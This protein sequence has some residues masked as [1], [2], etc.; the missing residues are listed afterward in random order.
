MQE[1][2]QPLS[3]LGVGPIGRVFHSQERPTGLAQLIQLLSEGGTYASPEI[4]AAF[5]PLESAGN[6]PYSVFRT[7]DG[8]SFLALHRQVTESVSV[9]SLTRK[10]NEYSTDERDV[11]GYIAA[12]KYSGI[13][14]VSTT[15]QDVLNA[16]SFTDF[17][18]S[19]FLRWIDTFYPAL[20]PIRISSIDLVS[21]LRSLD[22]VPGA[23]LTLLRSTIRFP[24]SGSQTTERAEKLQTVL[25]RADDEQGFLDRATIELG[26][27]DGYTMSIARTGLL[28]YHCGSLSHA[29]EDY[30]QLLDR[31][32]T[33]KAAVRSVDANPTQTY[34]T[35]VQIR[36]T[37]PIRLGLLEAASALVQTLE[38]DPLYSVTVMHGNPYLHVSVTDLAQGATYDVFSN[39]EGSLRV[40]P[41]RNAHS[42]SLEHLLMRIS[43]NFSDISSIEVHQTV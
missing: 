11:S 6:S 22:Q 25:A 26:G 1:H 31:A 5:V 41:G 18:D 3:S 4:A 34:P 2:M 21:F 29:L 32:A 14:F 19:C 33:R 28:L 13:Q 16:R 24:H 37:Q 42:A 40:Y 30:A 20:D 10:V 38:E 23:S 15:R 36:F 39:G 43:Q 9:H 8:R 12:F 17:R 7:Y 35:A 27:T